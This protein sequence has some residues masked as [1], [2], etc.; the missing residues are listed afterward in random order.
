MSAAETKVVSVLTN[1]MCDYNIITCHRKCIANVFLFVCGIKVRR[2]FYCLDHPLLHRLKW[3]SNT[4]VDC[5]R[6]RSPF[7]RHLPIIYIFLFLFSDTSLDQ[8]FKML[9]IVQIEK[10][11]LRYQC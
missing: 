11:L 3:I 4:L 2:P 6:G 1:T 5:V 8:N 10:T 7:D 9:N